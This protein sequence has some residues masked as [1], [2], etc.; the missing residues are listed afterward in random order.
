MKNFINILSKCEKKFVHLICLIDVSFASKYL[1]VRNQKKFLDLKNPKTFNEKLMYLKLY[2]YQN[3]KVVWRCVDKYC[4]REYLKSKGIQEKNLPE[5]IETYTNAKDINFEELPNKFVLKCTHGCGFNIVCTDK[6][7]LNVK[8]TR[9]ILNGWLNKKYGYETAELQYIHQKP[10]IICEKY[11]ENNDKLPVDYKIY[12]FHGEPKVILVCSNRAK[13]LK[14]NY[15]D[16]KWN[17]LLLGKKS[18]RNLNGVEKPKSLTSMIKLARLSSNEF[19]FVRV[20][21]YENNDMPI[22]GELTFTP[23]ACIDNDYTEEGQQYLGN[24]LKI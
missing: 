2:N 22:I 17:E 21:F 18:N 6:K 15:Y 23:A 3:N 7:Q 14:F 11:I 10:I 13:K 12:C 8:K 4:V 5:I 1:F 24:L 19:P 9:K 20:D 16:I